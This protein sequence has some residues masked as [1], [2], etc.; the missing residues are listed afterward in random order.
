MSAKV[1]I[2]ACILIGSFATA[3]DWHWERN[4]ELLNPSRLYPTGMN[5]IQLGDFDADGDQ[6]LING[7]KGGELQ[8]YENIGTP[9]SAIWSKNDAY[10]STLNFSDEFAPQ[11]ALADLNNDG[12]LEL[13]ITMIDST[14]G[15]PYD[16]LKMFENAGTPEQPT[17]E[18][19]IFSLNGDIPPAGSPQFI[20]YDGDGDLDLLLSSYDHGPYYFENIGDESNPEFSLD[21]DIFSTYELPFGMYSNSKLADI[22]GD[23]KLELISCADQYDVDMAEITYSIN[24][25]TV[26]NPYWTEPIHLGN[27]FAFARL[28]FADIDNDQDLDLFV[29]NYQLPI[30]YNVNR[31]NPD[32]FIFGDDLRGL[33]LGPLYIGWCDQICFVDYDNDADFD[34]AFFY[35]IRSIWGD[36]Y[37][38]GSVAN[39]GTSALPFFDY[40]Q[41]FFSGWAVYLN[42]VHMSAGDLD[43]DGFPE[44]ALSLS[45]P[46][47]LLNP[48]GAGYNM[49]NFVEYELDDPDYVRYPELADFDGDGLTDLLIRNRND[50]IWKCYRNTGTPYVPQWTDYPQWI[51]GIEAGMTKFRA[52]NLNRDEKPV[53]VGFSDGFYGYINTGIGEDVSF[54]Y[55]P[56]I[57]SDNAYSYGS[58]YDCADIDGDGDDDLLIDSAGVIILVE[59]Q[60]PLVVSEADRRLPDKTAIINSFPNPFNA[61]TTIQFELASAANVRLSVYDVLGRQ[62]AVL[63]DN[64]LKAGQQNLHWDGKNDQG[65]I[66]PSGVYYYRLNIGGESAIGRAIYLK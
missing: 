13:Y 36:F 31:G 50:L 24:E 19:G 8:Y 34:F 64:Y 41:G 47:F 26:E 16:S 44:L 45:T 25:G 5:T 54:A 29:T 51:E 11:P 66:L 49:N 40:Q 63:L 15:Q 65:D 28:E 53:L 33:P 12:L 60:T 27:S 38:N 56:D 2:L 32:V 23:E 22:Q 17:W 7:C 58:L 3:Q 52:A 30:F 46:F 10:F 1:T 62:V 6:D 48:G 43:G 57:F 9:D 42:D 61:G 21:E 59:N 39:H 35:W 14:F 37:A 55:D 4:N 20:D 18:E